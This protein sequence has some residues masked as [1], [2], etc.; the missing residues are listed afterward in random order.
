MLRLIDFRKGDPLPE[1]ALVALGPEVLEATRAIIGRVRT[2]GDAAL[3]SLT[4][5][6]DG[7]DI[8][9]RIEVPEDE[10]K[11]AASATPAELRR[12]IDHMAERLVAFHTRQLPEEWTA[13]EAGVEFGETVKPLASAGCYVPGGL[14][15]Y[16]STVLMTVVPAKV[17]GVARAV[18]CSPPGSDGNLPAAVLYAAATAKADAVYRVG[19]AQ[20]IAAMAFGTESVEP[21]DKIVGPGNVWVTAAKSEVAGSVGIDG[22]NGPTELV[23]V[24][25]ESAEP[26]TLALDLVAQA[27]H[28]PLAR[29]TLICT[30]VT[31]VERVNACIGGEVEAST[32]RDVVEEAL[33][34][35]VGIVVE[36][37]DDAA[38]IVDRMAPE[39]L[40]VVT[41]NPA[42]FLSRVRSYGAAFLGP[43]TPVSFGDYGIGSNHVLPTMAT[44]RFSSGLRA[45]DFVT[46]SSVVDASRDGLERYGEEIETLAE[47]EGLPGHARAS[48]IRRK[49]R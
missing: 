11:S 17:A 8:A 45:A 44:A 12:A 19:G 23:V 38:V 7:A 25:D 47:A 5:E 48:R 32:R 10:I 49:R 30:E 14:A 43:S 28:D 20:A 22:L 37:E 27:E 6:L 34:N 31:L 16:P 46:V 36:N 42:G 15:A 18:V 40:Q 1:P 29:T 3:V 9:G 2:E 39:H 21:V 41:E 35:A 33:G 26:E 13:T 24:A 4:K